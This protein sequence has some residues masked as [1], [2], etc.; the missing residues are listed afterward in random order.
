MLKGGARIYNTYCANCH[1]KNGKGDGNLF[2]PLSGSDWVAGGNY[3]EKES[4]IRVVLNGLE[5]P[6]KVNGKPYNSVMP[7]HNFLSDADIAAV[8]TYVRNSF[9]NN[10]SLVTVSEVKKVRAERR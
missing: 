9:G 4:V 5:G 10:N 6:I 8:L 2:P 7:K 1:Q 3:L